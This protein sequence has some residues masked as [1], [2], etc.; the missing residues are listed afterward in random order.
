MDSGR[1]LEHVSQLQLY[2][3]RY[4]EGV[5]AGAS[6]TDEIRQQVGVLAQ[7][8]RDVLP[9]AVHETVSCMNTLQ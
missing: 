3:Y 4:R 2:Q 8:L 6:S 5:M 7:E 9:D 1:Q